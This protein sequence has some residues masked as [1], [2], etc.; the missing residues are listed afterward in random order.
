MSAA[1]PPPPDASQDYE[2]SRRV[3]LLALKKLDQSTLL[4]LSRLSLPEIEALR[5]E[6]AQVLPAG[7]LPA[8]IL[9]GL[10]KLKGRTVKADQVNRD[11]TVLF[12]G[13]NLVPQGLYGAFVI[14][15]ATILYA[16]QKLLQLAGKDAQSAFPEGTWQFYLQFGLRGDAARH[17]NETVGFQR[18]FPQADPVSAAAAWVWAIADL[19]LDYD[20]LLATDWTERVSLRLLMEVATATGAQLVRDWNTRRPYALPADHDPGGA[21]GM[22]VHLSYRHALFQTFLSERLALLPDQARREFQERYQARLVTE[23]HAYQEQMTLLCALKPDRYQEQREPI[24]VWRARIGFIW[25]GRTYLIPLYQ[26]DAWGRPLCYP[27]IPG[28]GSTGLTKVGSMGLTKE[29]KVAEPIPLHVTDDDV[30]TDPGGRPVIVNRGGRV[31]S[32]GGEQLLGRLRPP[33]PERIKGRLAAT[34]EGL[35]LPGRRSRPPPQEDA[36]PLD[37]LLTESPRARQGELR[38][39]LSEATQAEIVRLRLAPIILNWDLRPADAPLPHIR[40]GQRGIGDHALT[41][42]RTERSFVFDQSHIFFDGLWGMAVA[43]LLTN[44]VV[45]RY[46]QMVD[47]LPRPPTGAPRPLKLVVPPKVVQLAQ[48]AR[49]RSAEPPALSAVGQTGAS[50]SRRSPGEATAEDDGVHTRRLARLRRWLSQ[51]GVRLTVNDLLLLYRYLYAGE[52][53]PSPQARRAIEGFRARAARPEEQ[54]AVQ[55]IDECLAQMRTANPALLIPMDASNVAPRERIFPTTFR[56]PLVEISDQIAIVNQ[57]YQTYQ[58][59]PDQATWA[60]FDQARREMLAYLQAFGEVLDALKAVTMRGE[61]FNTATI[62]MLAH[63]PASMQNLLDQ[64]PQHIGVL[65]DIIKGTEVFSNV[66]RVARGS[67]LRRFSSARDDGQTKRLIWGV[68]TDD[69]GVMHITL[70][71]FRPFVP[72]LLQLEDPSGRE[73][74]DLLA[75]DFLEGYVRGFNRF[76]VKLGAVV[77]EERPTE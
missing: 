24:P 34:L 5:Q 8:F 46:S 66:G 30:L 70:R 15:P 2:T 75:R 77:S 72:R 23:L 63:L 7:K 53:Q 49:Q 9:S 26:R 4:K 35:P 33:S 51:R 54:A 16:Y 58:D 44:Q 41:I 62:R 43:E 3:T 68:L 60:A 40:R 37:L 67:S 29:E 14:G 50:G 21:P 20:D 11:L 59:K 45:Y 10:L 31:W 64:I 55:A 39:A 61:S 1:P 74:A 6:V 27:T 32:A 48:K 52:Y 17:A 56:N 36:A 47:V 69:D 28:D 12:Q 18:A 71:D 76:M 38:A 13:I 65:N 42:F 25:R 22:N 73:L 19:I 57:A